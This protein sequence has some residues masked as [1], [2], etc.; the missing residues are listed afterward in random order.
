M[1]TTVRRDGDRVQVSFPHGTELEFRFPGV[2]RCATP[3]I[4]RSR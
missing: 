1:P 3:P 2:W 4:R